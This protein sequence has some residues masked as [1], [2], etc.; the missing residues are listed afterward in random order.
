MIFARSWLS[1]LLQAVTDLERML[2]VTGN[3]TL[4]R[5][6]FQSVCVR[7]QW[8]ETESVIGSSGMNSLCRLRA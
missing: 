3:P 5:D 2:R 6:V 7:G 4:C 1:L 8:S